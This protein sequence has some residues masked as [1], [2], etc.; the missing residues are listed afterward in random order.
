MIGIGI[1]DARSGIY[2]KRVTSLT[3]DLDPD[4]FS[5]T[6]VLASPAPTYENYLLSPDVPCF[7]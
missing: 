5:P 3:R 2:T 6:L 7:V 1:Y 4:L